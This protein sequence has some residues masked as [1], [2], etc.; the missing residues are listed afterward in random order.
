MSKKLTFTITA[1]GAII[2]LTIFSFAN[3]FA[4][5][6]ADAEGNPLTSV[7]QLCKDLKGSYEQDVAAAKAKGLSLQLSQEDIDAMV[8]DIKD[9]KNLACHEIQEA[10]KI[11]KD[12]KKNYKKDVKYA[13]AKGLSLQLT[14]EEIDA[15]IA[16]INAN[17]KFYCGKTATLTSPVTLCKEAKKNYKI[18]ADAAKAKGLSLQLSQEEINAMIKDIKDYRKKICKEA[19]EEQKTNK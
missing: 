16:D 9:Y 10:A 7:K 1:I 2:G 8:K 6:G 14:Q 19:K 15:I 12:L 17:R 5:E 11:C 4:L 3:A 18:N 13:K